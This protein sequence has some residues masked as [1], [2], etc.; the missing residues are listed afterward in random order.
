M[1][2]C[3]EDPGI[4]LYL[5]PGMEWLIQVEHLMVRNNQSWFYINCTRL[6]KER[7]K[8]RNSKE[9]HENINQMW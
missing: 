5:M 6:M 1:D 4:S 8:G 2:I 9:D 7:I 3:A